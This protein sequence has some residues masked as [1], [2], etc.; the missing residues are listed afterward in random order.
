MLP[1]VLPF[2]LGFALVALY[3]RSKRAASSPTIS[4]Q[5]PS[6]LATLVAMV[7]QGQEPPPFVIECALAE[8]C[9]M[10]NTYLCE[11][12]VRTFVE[13][14]VRAAALAQMQAPQARSEDKGQ[15]PVQTASQDVAV[16]PG[17][18]A[19]DYL[20]I[21]GDLDVDA[22][23][24]MIDGGP[25]RAA[26]IRDS[27]PETVTV[28]GRACPIEGIEPDEWRRFVGAL[29]RTDADPAFA[30]E[31]HIGKYRHRRDRLAELGIRPDSIVGDGKA[32]ERALEVDM[33]DAYRHAMESGL[34]SDFVRTTVKI[35]G[36]EHGITL[37]GILG[38]VQAAGL[39]GAA[40]WLERPS[41]R[42]RFP[43]TTKIFL[44][45]NGVF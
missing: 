3:R 19:A 26:P 42:K 40:E 43:H 13:P 16:S 29:E 1:L 33:R 2:A 6:A 32:Q 45:T 17:D 20:P 30:T 25:P 35:D 14:T 5:A 34:V 28:A 8:A 38:V 41:D 18:G 12:I 22:I 27:A 4:G 15:A 7:R 37:S 44:S 23:R 24:Q 31:R 9:S 36:K 10:G 11:Q 21:D 39:E